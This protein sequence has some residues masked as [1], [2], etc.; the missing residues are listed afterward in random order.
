MVNQMGLI[1]LF[2]VALFA[3]V[4]VARLSGKVTKTTH[5]GD[6]EPGDNVTRNVFYG[7]IRVH[8]ASTHVY[9]ARGPA[10][11]DPEVP[12]PAYVIFAT[13]EEEANTVAMSIAGGDVASVRRMGDMTVSP[14]YMLGRV[15]VMFRSPNSVKTRHAVLGCASHCGLMASNELDGSGHRVNVMALGDGQG[16]DIDLLHLMD[17]NEFLSAFSDSDAVSHQQLVVHV[18]PLDEPLE[19]FEDYVE[20]MTAYSG[21]RRGT[22]E[23]AHIS[24]HATVLDRLRE[25]RVPILEF[26]AVLGELAVPDAIP[27]LQRGCG[28]DKDADEDSGP[29]MSSEDLKSARYASLTSSLDLLGSFSSLAPTAKMRKICETW[30]YSWE[31][32]M[33]RHDTLNTLIP[34]GCAPSRSESVLRTELRA[35]VNPGW[36]E[37]WN[38]SRT[39]ASTSG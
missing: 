16:F 17:I 28:T 36:D 5:F 23:T 26:H 9:T 6:G 25:L 18:A 27:G 8:D 22:S 19:L 30:R 20:T 31:S 12:A 39:T 29:P 13:N 14:G 38:S 34:S 10:P 33:T 35:T 21:A 4:A 32:R 1:S 15:V 3:M 24:A 7:M 37:R 2:H 11:G